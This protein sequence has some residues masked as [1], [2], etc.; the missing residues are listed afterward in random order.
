MIEEYLMIGIG[1]LAWG[2]PSIAILAI[3]LIVV[4]TGQFA[5]L[6]IASGRMAFNARKRRLIDL[7][8]LRQ[9]A[10]IS[11]LKSELQT[12]AS[13]SSVVWRVMEVA[14]VVD[15]SADCRSF[16]LLDAYRQPLPP[17]QPGQHVLVRPAMAG[18]YQTTRCYSLSSAPDSRYWRLT[19]KRQS[20][21]HRRA[22]GAP[23]G[24]PHHPPQMR[25]VQQSQLDQSG[26]LSTWLHS[27]ISAGDCLLVG[28]PSGH[29]FLSES[30]PRPVILLAGGVGITPIAAML[31]WS[32]R[33][34]PLRPIRL[35]YQAQN[36]SHWPLGQALHQSQGSCADGRVISYFSRAVE[37]DLALLKG[38]L[39]GELRL[40][41]FQAGDAVAAAGGLD[42]D[43]YMCGPEAWMAALRDGLQN[44]GV[45]ADRVHWESFG[46]NAPPDAAPGAN[47]DAERRATLSFGSNAPPTAAPPVELEQALPV[48][49]ER[50]CVQAAWSDPQQSLWELARQHQ[51]DIPS[52]CLSGV[53]GGCR[54]KLLEG[55]VTHDRPVAIDLA[56][57]ECLA[58]IA[59]PKTPCRVDV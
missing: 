51:V 6:G 30:N 26:G 57:G 8:G 53:C 35:L 46:S 29:F 21:K 11:R 22:E 23:L 43:Y 24:R 38:R 20:P 9:A 58:C 18:A 48:R 14:E 45:K 4:S 27:S 28:G 13:G 49:F 33:A 47:T 7:R 44:A 16:Y 37:D 40:G 59:R 19:V 41:K 55:Q 5:A 56:A 1:N 50:S 32:Q 12:S 25:S 3:A 17:F 15:E 52:G 54:V 39:P 10:E 31:L 34:T 2:L 42:C 36:L